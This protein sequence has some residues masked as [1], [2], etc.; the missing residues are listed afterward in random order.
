MAINL[1]VIISIVFVIVIAAIV[2]LFVLHFKKKKKK[3]PAQVATNA[4]DIS[5]LQTN[6]AS[7]KSTVTGLQAGKGFGKWGPWTIT[8]SSNPD[9]FNICLNGET[10]LQLKKE[11]SKNILGSGLKV[12][13][14]YTGEIQTNQLGIPQKVLSSG[15]I[16]KGGYYFTTKGGV[17]HLTGK[18]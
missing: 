16:P 12:N 17:T 2:V 3:S 7:L 13:Y 6:V 5:N 4:E 9:A 14:I 10:Q 11:T 8:T 1:L 15:N 18:C